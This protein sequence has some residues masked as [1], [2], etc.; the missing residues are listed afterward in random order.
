MP[1]RFLLLYT[2]EKPSPL[3][4]RKGTSETAG[5]PGTFS[6]L[7]SLESL[8]FYRNPARGTAHS[9]RPWTGSQAA[10]TT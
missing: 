6:S 1:G 10:N 4:G 5:T 2:Q 3:G 8:L 9:S 7:L